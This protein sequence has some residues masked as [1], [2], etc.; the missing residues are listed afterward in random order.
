MRIF[1][2]STYVC[3]NKYMEIFR[4]IAST[5]NGFEDTGLGVTD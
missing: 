5:K 2:V 3:V 1:G 4:A